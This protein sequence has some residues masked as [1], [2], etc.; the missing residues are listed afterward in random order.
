MQS[1]VYILYWPVI[2]IFTSLNQVLDAGRWKRPVCHSS[3]GFNNGAG[4]ATLWGGI[5]L[6]KC[7]WNGNNKSQFAFRHKGIQADKVRILYHPL[8]RRCHLNW[9]KLFWMSEKE[10]RIYS[11]TENKPNTCFKCSHALWALQ[12]IHMGAW[13]QQLHNKTIQMNGNFNYFNF[14]LIIKLATSEHTN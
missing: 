4:E 5:P 6:S 10:V 2:H 1:A 11:E 3:P 7:S 13:L 9:S 8:C 14:D 12:Y